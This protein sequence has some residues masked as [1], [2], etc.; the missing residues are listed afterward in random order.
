VVDCSNNFFIYK[1]WDFCVWGDY[2]F[3]GETS[4]R[5]FKISDDEDDEL[6]NEEF[7]VLSRV[8]NDRVRMLQI[9]NEKYLLA[10]GARSQEIDVFHLNPPEEAETKRMKR[11]RKYPESDKKLVCRDLLRQGDATRVSEGKL[12]SLDAY[13]EAD[14]SVKVN[15]LTFHQSIRKPFASTR[16]VLTDEVN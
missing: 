1:I 8:S 16:F 5:V 2:F 11:I 12:R 14:G 3:V 10:A 15:C 13:E 9:V 7:G 6:K 4:I